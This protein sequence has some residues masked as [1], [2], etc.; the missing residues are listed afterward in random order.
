MINASPRI[1]IVVAGALLDSNGCVL[2]QRRPSG[3]PLEGLWEFPGGKME[4]GET[5]EQALVRELREELNVE[6]D[7]ADLSPAGFVTAPLSGRH[8][9]LLLFLARRWRGQP[10]PVEADAI[11]WVHP[12]EMRELAMPAPDYPLTDQLTALLAR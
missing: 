5:P 10:H 1:M 12:A 8:L 2:L 11:D 3:D 7:A 4:P 9:V 6:L